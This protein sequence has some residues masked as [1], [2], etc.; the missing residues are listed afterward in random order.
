MF[1]SKSKK[2]C[3]DCLPTVRYNH[4]DTYLEYYIAEF[5]NLFKF[6][7]FL[8][9][10]KTDQIL[11]KYLTII[12]LKTLTFLKII[13][14]QELNSLSEKNFSNK[15]LLIA[16]ELQKIGWQVKF[17]KTK[18]H[19][20]NFFWITKKT[21]SKTKKFYY[22]LIPVK[23]FYQIEVDNKK[24]F[25][26]F[27]KQHKIN[28]NQSQSFKNKTK[29]LN[30]AKKI[31]YPLVVKPVYGTLSQHVFLNLKNP[32]ELLT[33]I[34]KALIYQPEFLIEKFIDG[35]LFRVTVLAQKET[36]ACQ[37]EAANVVGDGQKTVKEL[38][39]Y[40]N[41]LKLANQQKGFTPNLIKIDQELLNK[42]TE[43]R[44]SLDSVLE[45]GEKIYLK[46]KLFLSTGCDILEKTP[47]CHL[48]IKNLFLD[49]AKKIN[50]DL[51]GFDLICQDIGKDLN[52][53]N[54]HIL[55]ANTSPYLNMHDEPFSG[56]SAKVSEFLAKEVDKNPNRFLY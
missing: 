39:D 7:N 55:E 15:S 18:R 10:L 22:K 50:I 28:K 19:I 4:F 1:F 47:E 31:G 53:Q 24:V 34:D 13:K 11:E 43:K 14:W 21:G 49:I 5:L 40:K 37:R 29:A 20:N 17:S 48:S 33:V 56:K 6:L 25:Q 16:K 44:L 3:P 2:P 32:K 8:N 26:K 46:S 52:C 23:Q 54:Y 38:I 9:F 27:L 51:V 41:N 42:L 45:K 35:D 36:F 30:F 12:L